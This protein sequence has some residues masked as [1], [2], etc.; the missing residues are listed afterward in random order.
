MKKLILASH[1]PNK[2][3]EIMRILKGAFSI[4][5]LNEAGIHQDIPEPFNTLEENAR[6]KSGFIFQLTGEDCFGEDTGL[7]VHSLGGEPGVRS[8]RY[9]GEEAIAEQNIKKLLEALA[10]N[11]DRDARFRTVIS[12][13]IEGKEYQFEGICNG[14]IKTEPAGTKGFGYDSVFVPV[15]S[16][17][18]FAE[19]SG[20]EKDIFSHRR[21]ALEKMATFLEKFEF[22]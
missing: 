20:S 16:E 4:Q 17:K 22:H 3:I 15:G 6:Q 7:E 19:M 21:K 2:A 1:N 18:S 10:G 8:A 9:A 14:K 12:L 11:Q 13:I 5:T